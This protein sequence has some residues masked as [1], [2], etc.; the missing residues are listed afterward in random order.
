MNIFTPIKKVAG[1]I[2]ERKLP[3]NST[4]KVKD[5]DIVS[6][7]DIL[8]ETKPSAGFH[9]I[10]AAVILGIPAKNL[11]QYVVRKEGEKI[12]KG[13]IVAEKTKILSKETTKVTAPVDGI[14]Q[15]IN[16]TNGQVLLKMTRKHELI[17]TGVW[18][19]VVEIKDSTIKIETQVIEVEGRAGRGFERNGAIKIIASPYEVI[20]EY[21]I[22]EDHAGKIIVG[23]SMLT[24]EAITK[25]INMGVSGCIVGGIDYKDILSVQKDSDIGFTM[26]ALEGY[27]NIAINE[28]TYEELK[29]CDNYYS[30]INGIE[31]K[32]LIPMESL[33]TITKSVTLSKLKVGTTIRIAFDNFTGQTGVVKD[34]IENYPLPSGI[35]TDVA[36]IAIHN[37][38]Q[39]IPLANIEILP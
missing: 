28:K 39:V 35:R 19:K 25:C 26:V 3:N 11:K 34:L 33:G 14:I 38:E 15:S 23:G 21:M 8:A 31:K 18:G 20:R 16:D 37:T 6:P 12:Y 27:G 36:K 30:F 32:L 29:K 10:N 13:E 1:K 7:S 4:I 17:P 2:I 5:G 9:I 22:N 24:R